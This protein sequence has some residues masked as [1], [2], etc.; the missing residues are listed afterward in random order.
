MSYEIKT[1]CSECLN[2]M[3]QINPFWMKKQKMGRNDI[4][5]L[6]WIY[7]FIVTSKLKSL[8]DNEK[9][10]G[11]E[12]WPIIDYRKKENVRTYINYLLQG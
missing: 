5:S 1:G 9:L 6:Y 12:F 7:E 4:S 3:M 2:G 11:Y 10:E 8:I